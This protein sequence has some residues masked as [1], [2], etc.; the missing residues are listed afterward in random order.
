MKVRHG[1][2]LA[3][4]MGRGAWHNSYFLIFRIE[5]YAH[6]ELRVRDFG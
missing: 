1:E 2:A 5:C 3:G 6:M 4:T